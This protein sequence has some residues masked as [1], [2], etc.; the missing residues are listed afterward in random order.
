MAY[1]EHFALF[2][3]GTSHEME[4]RHRRRVR[5]QKEKFLGPRPLERQKRFFFKQNIA[6]FHH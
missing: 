5:K 4:V 6:R 3:N 2:H 1:E